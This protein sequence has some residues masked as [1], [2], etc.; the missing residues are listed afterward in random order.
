V[1]L[2]AA[3]SSSFRT[4]KSDLAVDINGD[5]NTGYLGNNLTD[6]GDTFLDVKD[7]VVGNWQPLDQI[8]VAGGTNQL[9]DNVFSSTGMGGTDDA[10]QMPL[11][12]GQQAKVDA[13]AG[14]RTSLPTPNTE[15]AEIGTIPM[16][17]IYNSDYNGGSALFSTNYNNSPAWTIF[18]DNANTEVNDAV[19]F[20]DQGSNM[21]YA[22]EL[23]IGQARNAAASHVWEYYDASTGWTAFTPRDAY[24]YQV[25]TGVSLPLSADTT[26]NSLTISLAEGGTVFAADQIVKIIDNDSPAIYRRIGALTTATLLTFTEPVPA[27]YTTAQSATVTRLNGGQWKS[28]DP[29]SIFA[30]TGRRVLSWA[31]S[32][33]SGTPAKTTINGVN[34][35]WV[36]ARISSFTSWTTSPT[37]QT[38]PVGMGGIE[39]IPSGIF[40]VSNGVQEAKILRLRADDKFVPQ[41]VRNAQIDILNEKNC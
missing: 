40:N 29:A 34:A 10:N 21:P 22:L 41:E 31:P 17:N 13:N 6:S 3:G 36:R 18:G 39:R 33:L 25:R 26:A 14:G 20:G 30:S 15:I 12:A 32:N 8:S 7:N 16:T 27:G 4:S 1:S 23:N 28:M 5:I 9:A 38:T 35:Y 2:Y 19:Y 11:W 37:N 24:T